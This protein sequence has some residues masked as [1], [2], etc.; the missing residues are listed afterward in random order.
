MGLDFKTR[1]GLN[2]SKKPTHVVDT[3]NTFGTRTHNEFPS[4]KEPV[5]FSRTP[6][7]RA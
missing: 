5:A 6:P 3:I 7:A 1:V 4:E 2:D